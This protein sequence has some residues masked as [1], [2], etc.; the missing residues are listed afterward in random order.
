MNSKRLGSLTGRVVEFAPMILIMAI[1]AFAAPAAF[2]WCMSFL[3]GQENPLTSGTPFTLAQVMAIFGGFGL[4]GGFSDRVTS[5][6]RRSLRRMATMYLISALCFC[7]MGMLLP[8]LA[9][10]EVATASIYL[11]VGSV[12]ASIAV[13]SVTFTLATFLWAYQVRGLIDE[14]GQGEPPKRWSSCH[15]NRGQ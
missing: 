10:V 11:L 5:D 13:A 12:L 2:I 14:D 6:L 4:V 9:Y 7:L 3:G 15:C 8:A 1:G